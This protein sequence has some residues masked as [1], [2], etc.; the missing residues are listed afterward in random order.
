MIK[1]K[2]IKRSKTKKKHILSVSKLIKPVNRI[3]R[4]SKYEPHL[5]Y[6]LFFENYF[7]FNYIIIKINDW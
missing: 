1:L 2:I 5:D 7:L 3:S 4:V 6:N